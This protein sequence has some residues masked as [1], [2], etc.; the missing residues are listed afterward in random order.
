VSFAL[1]VNSAGSRKFLAFAVI[2]DANFKAIVSSPALP[3]E[4]SISFIDKFTL[5][6]NVP[7]K[8]SITLDGVQEGAG[9]NSIQLSPGTHVVSVP[10]MVQIDSTSRLKFNGWSDGSTQT[11][12][13]F[14]LESDTE[15]QAMYVTQYFVSATS[16][17]TLASGWYDSG[18]IVQFSV[19]E[20]QPLNGYRVVVGGFD[21]WYNGGQLI[22]KSASASITI[23]G[24]VDLSATWNILPYVPPVVTIAANV[25]VVLFYRRRH[26]GSKNVYERAV[27]VP[28]SR[29]RTCG[30]CSAVVPPGARFCRKCGARQ[31]L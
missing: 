3:N 28:V 2:E 18:T 9:S 29:V 15:I 25:G 11:T 1:T 4:F 27:A 23:T 24:P 12:R 10:G 17:S 21:G 26:T 8:V 20:A 6:V 31:D 19:N 13:A 30:S 16:D 7:S 14:D 22:S 5:T